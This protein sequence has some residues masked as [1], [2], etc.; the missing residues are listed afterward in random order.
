MTPSLVLLWMC[1]NDAS[2]TKSVNLGFGLTACV[3]KAERR[4]SMENMHMILRFRDCGRLLSFY[5][6][7]LIRFEF[8][9]EYVHSDVRHFLGPQKIISFVIALIR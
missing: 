1:A 6:N 5:F 7:N 3:T 2:S 9:F 8:A 4:R